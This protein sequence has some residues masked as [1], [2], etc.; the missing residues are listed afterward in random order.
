MD[1][2]VEEAAD[3]KADHVVAKED[4]RAD[5]SRADVG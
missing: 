4:D 2:D 5:S 1:C 3:P